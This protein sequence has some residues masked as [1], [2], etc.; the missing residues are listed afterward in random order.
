MKGEKKRENGLKSSWCAKPK[1]CFWSKSAITWPIKYDL[2]GSVFIM[3]REKNEE[4]ESE[5]WTAENESKI[6]HN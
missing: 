6:Y 5:G 1:P 3:A 2:A 4:K